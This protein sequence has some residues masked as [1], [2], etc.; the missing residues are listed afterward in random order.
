[1]RKI[2]SASERSVYLFIYNNRKDDFLKEE[3]NNLNP[4]ADRSRV[5]LF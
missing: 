4:Q 3:E 1:M 2:V 5:V